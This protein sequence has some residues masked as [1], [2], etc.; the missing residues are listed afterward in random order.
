MRPPPR[1]ALFVEGSWGLPGR[2]GTA[3]QQIWNDSLGAMLGIPRLE[4]IVPISKANLV[5][6]DPAKPKSVGAGEALDQLIVRH[7]HRNEFDAAVVAWDLEPRWD[8]MAERCRWMETI[9]L[10]RLLGQSD[11][12]PDNWRD[13]ARA[14]Y[15]ELTGRASAPT[16]IAPLR[17]RPGMVLALCMEPMFESLLVRDEGALRRALGVAGVHLPNWP[18]HG[19]GDQT[20]RHPDTRLVIPAVQA[21]MA[22]PRRRHPP[23]RHMSGTARTDKDSWNAF[24]LRRLLDD[25]GGR[26][27]VLTHPI[28]VRLNEMLG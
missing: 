7:L 28:A 9:E 15:V 18:G 4:P 25:V 16:R 6:L 17:P 1:I 26:H 12:L 24:L 8:T 22:S 27:L 14:R 2:R 13:V 10:Y 19:W 3:L 11:H 23:L 20:T 21:A 5:S